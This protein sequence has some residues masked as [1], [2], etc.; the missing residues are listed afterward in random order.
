MASSADEA[1]VVGVVGLA[2]L[3]PQFFFV[4]VPN[5]SAVREVRDLAGPINTGTRDGDAPP[6]LGE[7]VLD[8]YGLLAAPAGGTGGRASVVRPEKGNVADFESGHNVAETRR[9]R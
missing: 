7:R 3:D 9:R 2:R 6:T 1:G 4:I 8:Y 5:D